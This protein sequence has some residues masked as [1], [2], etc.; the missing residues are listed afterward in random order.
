MK[1]RRTGAMI[2]TAVLLTVSAGCA[3]DQGQPPVTSVSGIAPTENAGSS[4]GDDIPE[5]QPAAQPDIDISQEPPVD[6]GQEAPMKDLYADAFRIGVAVQAIDHWNDPTAEI[7]NPDKEELICREFN[8]MTFG[9]EWKPAYN[10]D[11][12]SPT[13]YKTDRAAEEL[14]TWAKEHEM[15]VR[16]HT[17]VWHSQV[18]PSIFAKDF[19][20][21][22]DGSVT[23]DEKKTLDEACLVSR[24][25]LIER[26]RTYIYG[27]MEY[28]YKNGFASTVYA[29]DVLNEATDEARPDGLRESYWYKIIGPEFIYY[30]FLFAREAEVTYAHEYAALYGLDP[31]SD[32]LSPILPKLFYND[33]NEWYDQRITTITRFLTQDRYNEGGKL[34][35][36][37]VIAADGDGTIVGDGLIDGIGMQGHLDD[38]Q[39]IDQYIKAL[40]AYDSIVSEVQITELDVG[41]TGTGEM[42]ET[43]QAAFCNAFFRALLEERRNGVNLTA[44][45]WWG[46]TDDASWRRGA[47]PLL[48]HGDLSAKPAYEALQMAHR[49]EIYD[50]E[51]PP[52]THDTTPLFYDFEPSV[53]SGMSVIKPEDFGFTSRGSGHQAA[54]S[55]ANKV[56][57]TPDAPIGRSLLVSRA[58]RDATVRMDISRFI[59]ETVTISMYVKTEDSRIVLGVTGDSSTVL[60]SA[61]SGPDWTLV[62]ATCKLNEGLTSASVYLETDGSADIYID[63]VAVHIAE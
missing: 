34:I 56:N 18:D 35:K 17:M 45:T 38:T 61:S 14:L 53:S 44:V 47:N 8:S 59:G 6:Q 3:S 10:F 11:A 37:D 62:E 40:R 55:F 16:G 12:A 60:A 42:A 46:L 50:E 36:S 5:I 43:K 57:H 49:G 48:F 23:K 20:A 25:V 2:L 9:N 19:R 1:C 54:L 15:P 22:A 28:T 32:D 52:L 7:G 31:N 41:E 27:M 29:F 4:A 33:Y 51:N 63:D 39:N 58:E 30:C 24:D 21:T 26:L 13:L